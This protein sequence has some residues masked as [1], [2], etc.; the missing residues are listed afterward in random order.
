MRRDYQRD[1]NGRYF[2]QPRDPVTGKRRLVTADSVPQLEAKLARI[3]DARQDLRL[4]VSLA[5]VERRIMPVVAVRMTVEECFARYVAGLQR[6]KA[7]GESIWKNRLAPTFG[8][9]AVWELTADVMRAW[10]GEQRRHGHALATVK[11]A[12]DMLAAA[13]NL[14]IPAMIPGLPW[15][16]WRPER[17]RRDERYV[18]KRPALATLTALRALVRGAAESDKMHWQRG[19][20]SVNARC[21]VFMALTGLRQGE[22]VGL[23]WDRLQI[24]GGEP[25]MVVEYQGAQGW[26]SR[27]ADR[28]RDVPK[29]GVRRIHLHPTCVELLIRQREDLRS[30][31]WYRQDGPVWPKSGGGWRRNGKVLKPSN[32]QEWAKSAGLARWDEWC[33][34]SLRHSNIMLELLASGGD[35]VSVMQRSGHSDV[36][37]MRAYMHSMGEHLPHSRIGL[38]SEESRAM[39]PSIPASGT[40]ITEGAIVVAAS[41]SAWGDMVQTTHATT[42]ELEA[43]ALSELGN[44]ATSEVVDMRTEAR[45]EQRDRSYDPLDVIY[46][47]WQAAGKQGKQPREITDRARRAYMK[48][49][50]EALRACR[51]LP[52]RRAEGNQARGRFLGAWVAA[53]RR[54]ERVAPLEPLEPTHESAAAE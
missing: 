44:V 24:D 39:L 3:R 18:P 43:A 30:R 22:A 45:R 8:K 7:K 54:L 21:V 4:G 33:A 52:E 28:P 47:R 53:C 15:G 31:G 32:I 6:S 12:Y 51:P 16:K 1:A 10:E 36:Q 27:H 23:A 9:R 26:P 2:S 42:L 13:I 46:S 48:G 38:G 14:Q 37:V 25:V 20:Y 29:D 19:R 17:E 35:L 5:E 50:N 11:L 40:E 49:Y 41:G 34:H